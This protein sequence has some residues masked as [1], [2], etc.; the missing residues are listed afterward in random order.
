MN[1][2]SIPEKVLNACGKGKV[3]KRETKI[4]IRTTGEE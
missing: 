2:G 3:A 1:K 4:E